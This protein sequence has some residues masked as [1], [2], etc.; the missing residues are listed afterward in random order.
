MNNT[1]SDDSDTIDTFALDDGTGEPGLVPAVVLATDP[2]LRLVLSYLDGT[3][4]EVG[5]AEAP[6]PASGV[7]HLDV[8]ACD[9]DTPLWV[10]SLTTDAPAG[11]WA[12]YLRRHCPRLVSLILGLW[13]VDR[14]TP[15]LHL[16]GDTPAGAALSVALPLTAPDRRTRAE[17]LIEYDPQRLLDEACAWT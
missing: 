11:L 12:Q 7:A 10:V 17:A 1:D 2:S 5:V 6:L 15:A 16:R 4:C 14:A 8:Q 13:P 9:D 3:I